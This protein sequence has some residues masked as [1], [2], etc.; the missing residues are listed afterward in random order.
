MALQVD[1]V[2]FVSY[3]ASVN[4]EPQKRRPPQR[5]GS[6]LVH[7]SEEIIP[8]NLPPKIQKCHPPKRLLW[9]QSYWI[10]CDSIKGSSMRQATTT[11]SPS[12]GHHSTK[13]TR[14]V[15]SKCCAP[16]QYRKVTLSKALTRK[17][18]L[19]RLREIGSN[20]Y[21]IGLSPFP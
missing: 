4:Q 9:P 3:E 17:N 1:V 6:I 7:T 19:L 21:L 14:A 5:R 16:G 2:G 10:S 18:S 13:Q 15:E 20:S 12:L 11:P 8:P